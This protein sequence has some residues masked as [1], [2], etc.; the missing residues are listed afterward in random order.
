MTS[1]YL[2]RLKLDLAKSKG[3]KILVK[4]KIK[5]YDKDQ[6]DTPQIFN[7]SQIQIK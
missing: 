1:K 2:Q 4:G 3:K 7:P 6:K 5:T